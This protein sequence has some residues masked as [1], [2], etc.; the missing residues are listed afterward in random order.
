MGTKITSTGG[1]LG[2]SGDA[3]AGGDYYVR[4]GGED[5]ATMR[6]KLRADG[7]GLRVVDGD[8]PDGVYE[9]AGH[10]S[11]I[12]HPDPDVRGAID[13][14]PDATEE[15]DT[16]AVDTA[17]AEPVDPAGPPPADEPAPDTHPDPMPPADRAPFDP[18]PVAAE[19]VDV[20]RADE[21]PAPAP[22]VVV[23][24]HAAE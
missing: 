5:G 11:N 20:S 19:P 16:E 15:A 6:A 17:P 10:Y 3:L 8:L 23:D 1:A 24:E 4:Q 21:T 13:P 7:N 18:A 12:D 2:V 9:I 22:G 14:G